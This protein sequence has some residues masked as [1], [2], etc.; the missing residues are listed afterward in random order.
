MK[1][2]FLFLFFFD[3]LKGQSQVN[4]NFQRYSVED[5]LQNNIVL[6]AAE[7]T[8]GF[9]WFG[10][11]TGIDRFDG[12]FF[13]TYQLPSKEKYA[14]NYINVPFVLSDSFKNIWSAT[15]NAIFQ[16]NVKKDIFE[17]PAKLNQAI[18]KGITGLN[19]GRNGK[20]LFIGC[21]NKIISYSCSNASILIG[22]STSANLRCFYEEPNGL[23]WAGCNDGIKFFS[24]TESSLHQINSISKTLSFFEKS[25]ITNV[26]QDWLSRYWIVSQD[27]GVFVYI[28][29]EDIFKP[30]NLPFKY[31]KHNAVKDIL[32]DKAH[33]LTYISSDGEGVCV[34]DQNLK[35]VSLYSTNEDDLKS[36]SNNAAYDLLID[37]YSRLWVTTYGGGI[38]VGSFTVQPFINFQHALNN[39]NSLSNNA[40][41]AI[42]EDGNGNL[43]FGTRKGLSKYNVLN[44]SW[45]HLNKQNQQTPFISD[46]ILCLFGDGT[47]EIWCGTYGGGLIQ[48]EANKN[49]IKQWV[50]EPKDTTSLGTDFIYAVLKDKKDRVWTGGIRGPI[51]YFDMKSNKFHRINSQPT[52]VN[53]I[54]EDKKGHILFGTDRGVFVLS[55]DSL[56]KVF[57]EISSRV[58]CIEETSVGNYWIGTIGEGLYKISNEKIEKT[59][60][61]S[62]GLPADV[63]CGIV[64]DNN[65]DI[66]IG[67]SKGVC[68][69]QARTQQLT[70]FTSK[71]GLAGSQVNYGAA[72]KTKKGELI[73]G[74]TNGFSMFNPQAIKATGYK[75]NIVFTAISVNNKLFSASEKNSPLPVQ[76]DELEFLEL[77]HFQNSFTIDFV[78][79]S[80]QISGIHLYSWMLKGFDKT[81]SSPSTVPTA[82][83]T[84]LNSGKYQLLVKSISKG[85]LDD[86]K[87]RSLTIIISQPWWNT[88]WAYLG[89]L[90]LISAAFLAIKNYIEIRNTR[91]RFSER[92]RINTSISHE[93][94]TPLTLVKGPI[95]SLAK[96]AGLS[97]LQK[98][99]LA[100]AK[101]NIEKLENIVTQL[102]EFQKSGFSQAQ[103][104][105][106]HEDIIAFIE[107]IVQSFMPLIEEKNIKLSINKSVESVLLLF[108]KG[109]MEKIINNLMSNAVKYT[110][111][112]ESIAISITKD[113]KYLNISIKDTGI[114]IPK[115]QQ[116]LLFKGYFRGY[117]AENIKEAGSGVGL[118]LTSELV[119]MH[120]GKLSFSSNL[121][122]GSTFNLHF[123]LH[124]EFLQ[125]HIITHEKNEPPAI[126]LIQQSEQSTLNRKI[127]IVEDSDELRS[128]LEREFKNS[129]YN[130]YVAADGEE[131]IEILAKQ[132]IDIVLTDVM[133]PKINGFQLCHLIK[134]NINTCHVPVVMLT[135][136]DDKDYLLEGFRTGADDFIKKPFD[137][138]FLLARLNNL[139]SE[140]LR[141]R[142]KILSVFDKSEKAVQD[143]PDVA[144]LRIVT[145]VILENLTKVDFSVEK[146]AIHMAMSHSTLFRKFKEITGESA[147]NY[148]VKL[149]LRK[150]VELLGRK[151]ASIADVAFQ[152]GFAD[153]KYFS[154]V[155]KKHFGKS[156]KEYGSEG[157]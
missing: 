140:R 110:Q 128:Y 124:N 139:L 54:I 42:A 77:K 53:C 109:K 15:S 47:N 57:P 98:N 33:K 72:Y 85:R 5:G 138:E 18:D 117:N 28:A 129:G 101:S 11:A 24:K 2:L 75:P 134:N 125:P 17:I 39:A 148:I 43:W 80:P 41:K 150:A 111:E 22:Q 112:H 35:I 119:E 48:I 6:S 151:N 133:M 68:Q 46:N 52:L 107:N 89:Y 37:G 106:V 88:I 126:T 81:W 100:L 91:K 115:K 10:T 60:R 82:T 27:K 122:Q 157:Q 76:I 23:I 1:K 121:N 20:E 73:F 149:R 26:S 7:D 84:N 63:I 59:Y 147:Q 123:L 67:T 71:D 9:I 102:V 108:D 113:S 92:L 51:S 44:K 130:A 152:S 96:S 94:R 32:H 50:S 21:G 114:G 14:N 62:N 146:L 86:G 74:T 83:Y 13:R 79:T 155:F 64:S 120:K 16:Y 56:K 78:N 69:L 118:S 58:L 97:E 87:I 66:W 154:T 90:L 132:K 153:P 104:Q 12:K 36:L 4:L 29:N 135:S 142:N 99:N 49:K 70:T 8:K 45:T 30:V 127:L 40:A 105:V 95:H 38:N 137:L 103:M 55:G 116:H 19:L 144:W 141:F 131:A 145:E 136:I 61:V 34:L 93:I 31:G 65:G 25:S 143:D 3:F 156:P